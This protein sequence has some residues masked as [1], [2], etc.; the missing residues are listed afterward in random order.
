MTR[1][2]SIA[3]AVFIALLSAR[4]VHAES[5]TVGIMAGATAATLGPPD[6]GETITMSP[7]LAAFRMPT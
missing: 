3:V 1:A 2:L 4:A 5:G 7:G 6:T